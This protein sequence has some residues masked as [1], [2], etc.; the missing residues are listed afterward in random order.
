MGFLRNRLSSRTRRV[1]FNDDGDTRYMTGDRDEFLAQR[2][3]AV[4]NSD[5]D[6]YFW[7]VMVNHDQWD[8]PGL[9]DAN[10][11][12]IDAAR[13]HD[14]ELWASVRMNDTHD[15]HWPPEVFNHPENVELVDVDW[16]SCGWEGLEEGQKTLMRR[17]RP[18]AL[19][20]THPETMVGEQR[21]RWNYDV[22]PRASIMHMNWSAFDY[23]R[24]EVRR[25]YLERIERYCRGYDWDGLELDFIR[26]PVF[27]KPGQVEKN[28]PTMTGFVSQ[29]RALLDRIGE[30]RGRPYPLAVHVPDAPVYC[31][32]CGLDINAWLADDLVDLVVMGT[33]YRPHGQRY[34]EFAS[35]C[36]YYGLP[37]FVCL[38]CGTI[39]PDATIDGRHVV[40]RFRGRIS[41]M[42]SEDIDGL[43]LF[44]LFA[45]AMSGQQHVPFDELKQVGGPEKLI[46]KDKLY[47]AGSYGVWVDRDI[48]ADPAE[49]PRLVDARPVLL[50]IGDPVARLAREGRIRELRLQ[51]RV[52]ELLEEESVQIRINGCPVGIAD[53]SREEREEGPYS[54]PYQVKGGG[55]WFE[56]LPDA[57]PV[58]PGFNYVVVS[59]GEGCMGNAASYVENVQMWVRH[60]DNG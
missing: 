23:A 22:A 2:F 48:L 49:R 15:A 43:H 7:C 39:S 14:L 59:P 42:W 55:Y 4:L 54:G 58:R 31:L 11:V 8:A 19:K 50:K 52:S 18:F 51:V 60:T 12:M 21:M 20:Q 56:A 3:D 32:R 27:F 37:A 53:R 13:E 44:N 10:Q 35:L 45:S 36:H 40:E 34:G 33:G 46:G 28:I 25:F 16:Q 26:M 38:N 1:I 17:L 30:E 9:G 47:E 24:P 41:S 29:V 6:T 57:P 5:V